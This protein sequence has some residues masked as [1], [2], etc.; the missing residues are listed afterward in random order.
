M[1]QRLRDEAHRFAITHHRKLR[2]SRSVASR[3]E[4]IPGIGPKRRRAILTHFK[5]VEALRNAS[6][7]EIALV[8]G[9]NRENAEA[10]YRHLHVEEEN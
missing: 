10:V 1:I 9:V 6:V 4:E 8:P 7:D 5:T 3:L 2:A